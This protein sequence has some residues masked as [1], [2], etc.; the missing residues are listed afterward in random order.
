MHQIQKTKK[1]NDKNQQGDECTEGRIKNCA[2]KV[3]QTFFIIKFRKLKKKI[4]IRKFSKIQKKFYDKFV[5]K[6]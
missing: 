3:R 4:K 1:L 5:K 6:F 2:A